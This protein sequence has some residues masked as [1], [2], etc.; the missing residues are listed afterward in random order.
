MNA[1]KLEPNLANQAAY[2][3]GEAQSGAKQGWAAS[4]AKSYCNLF[5]FPLRISVS[6]RTSSI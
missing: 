4:Y 2:H 1:A 3:L 5:I 6:A